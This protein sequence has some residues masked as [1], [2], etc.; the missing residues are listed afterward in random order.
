M[1]V[2]GEL[3]ARDFLWEF[4]NGMHKLIREVVGIS[5]TSANRDGLKL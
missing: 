3:L 1:F 4:H 5:G 2:V